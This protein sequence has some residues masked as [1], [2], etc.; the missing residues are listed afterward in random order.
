MILYFI[1]YYPTDDKSTFIRVWTNVK[2]M[3]TKVH[4]TTELQWIKKLELLSTIMIIR[5]DMMKIILS[6]YNK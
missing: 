1:S 6:T 4:N 5:N 3:L 2:S